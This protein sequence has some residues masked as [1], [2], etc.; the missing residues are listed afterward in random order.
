MCLLFVILPLA[1]YGLVNP[2]SVGPVGSFTPT[3][4]QREI[5]TRG[6]YVAK[7]SACSRGTSGDP[8]DSPTIMISYQDDGTVFLA[9]PGGTVSINYP[10]RKLAFSHGTPLCAVRGASTASLDTYVAGPSGSGFIYIPQPN[11]TLVDKIEVVSPLAVLILY[12]L[13]FAGAV[14]VMD[15][16]LVVVLKRGSR[17]RRPMP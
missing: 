8:Q 14:V 15:V 5:P 11:G 13:I 6:E 2:F 7:L 1:V 10:Y 17:A 16:I 12:L 4:S 3:A 9:R